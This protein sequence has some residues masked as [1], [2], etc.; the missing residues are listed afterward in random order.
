MRTLTQSLT[1]TS[2]AVAVRSGFRGALDGLSESTKSA[3]IHLSAGRRLLKTYP[4]DGPLMQI[5]RST[6]NNFL[7]VGALKNGWID[8]ASAASFAGAGD[9]FVVTGYDQRVTSIEQRRNLWAWS[10]NFGNA[11]WG[12]IRG[13][14]AQNGDGSWRFTA[15]ENAAGENSLQQS[16]ATVTASTAQQWWVKQ[17]NTDWVSVLIWD[18]GANVVRQW[19]NLATLTLGSNTQS[20]TV[21]SLSAPST[22]V[23]EGD[24]IKLTVTASHPAISTVARG[25]LHVVEANGAFASVIGNF[26]DVLKAQAE[27]GS[28]IAYQ[29]V[30]AGTEYPKRFVGA[31][32]DSHDQ[33][34]STATA[35]PRLTIT[36][37]EEAPIYEWSAVDGVNGWNPTSGATVEV[38]D[39]KLRVTDVPSGAGGR[40]AKAISTVVGKSY[41]V[42][43]VP[44][45]W[46]NAPGQCYASIDQ[47]YGRNLGGGRTNDFVFTA[48][49]TTTYILL[50]VGTDDGSLCEWSEVRVTLAYTE[51]NRIALSSATTIGSATVNAGAGTITF[52]QSDDVFSGVVMVLPAVLDADA[53]YEVSIDCVAY[54]NGRFQLYS[55]QAT[56]GT[57]INVYTSTITGVGTYR[58]YV[59]MAALQQRVTIARQG[60]VTTAHNATFTNFICRKIIGTRRN[61][62]TYSDQ[63]DNTAWAKAGVS[64]AAGSKVLVEN[65]AVNTQH[66]LTRTVTMVTDMSTPSTANK[67]FGVQAKVKRIVGSRHFQIGL[68]LN[69]NTARIYY[70]LDAGTVAV[71]NGAIVPSGTIELLP[72]GEWLCKATVTGASITSANMF[73][74]MTNTATANAETYNGDGVSSLQVTDIQ[75]ELGAPTTYQ[76]VG[77]NVAAGTL[78]YEADKKHVASWVF[79]GSSDYIER[80]ATDFPSNLHT[81]PEAGENLNTGTNNSTFDTGTG[82]WIFSGT[83]GTFS[84]VGGVAQI[85]GVSNYVDKAIRNVG[86]LLGKNVIISMDVWSSTG[87]VNVFAQNPNAPFTTYVSTIVDSR[88]PRRV[89]LFVPNC[90]VSNLLA[91]VTPWTNNPAQVVNFDNVTFRELAPAANVGVTVAMRVDPLISTL[92]GAMWSMRDGS[93]GYL[94]VGRNTSGTLYIAHASDAGV[95]RLTNSQVTIGV[96]Q[97]AVIVAKWD[98]VNATATLYMSGIAI[99]TVGSLD[100][101]GGLTRKPHLLGVTKA[102]SLVAYWNG[103][104]S[105]PIIINSAV[106]DADRVIIESTLKESLK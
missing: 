98:F 71:V 50:V 69:N 52:A 77:S 55:E 30:D 57:G 10:E 14:V 1:L 104:I 47:S 93:N 94:T 88:T 26:V 60:S 78:C 63:I 102:P 48:T 29:R 2:I 34:Q 106:S 3:I 53:M 105:E 25:R 12:K 103:M 65:N 82:N 64:V 6:D 67:T 70:D 20:G 72:S 36:P 90:P 81:L 58:F 19:F 86:N 91:V 61:L 38:V 76:R 9:L 74:A 41:R 51:G 11:I 99:G 13:A 85:T 8:A 42:F 17:G 100:I 4:A 96:G 16:L 62:L 39:G 49:T 7:D 66:R 43:A 79:D 97:S 73:L 31:V 24:W 35:Q 27:V 84:A 21:I 5:R 44:S 83:Q 54:T 15:T 59:K 18:G 101:A 89:Q 37:Q 22:I 92:S 46:S 33:T 23:Q 45:G 68:T 80:P 56:T 40:A 32:L 75:Y 95:V 28:S 87:G